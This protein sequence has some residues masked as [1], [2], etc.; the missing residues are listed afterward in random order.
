MT[1]SFD[2]AQANAGSI[3]MLA[4]ALVAPHRT[5]SQVWYQDVAAL[6]HRRSGGLNKAQVI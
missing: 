1:F 3:A 2:V 4:A 5:Y 6:S